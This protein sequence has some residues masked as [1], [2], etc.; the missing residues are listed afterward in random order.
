MKMRRNLITAIL[1]MVLIIMPFSVLANGIVVDQSNDGASWANTGIDYHEPIGQ[2]FIPSMSPLVGVDV[3]LAI[4]NPTYG[5]ANITVNIREDTIDGAIVATTSQL[6]A[7][8]FS[9]WN[10]FEFPSPVSID[11]GETYV[12][13]LV[14]DTITHGWYYNYP[15]P[16]TAGRAIY[17]GTANENQDLLFRTYTYVEPKP[18]I[19]EFS[20]STTGT[21]VEYVE[22]FG[23]PNTDYSAYT[24]LEIEGDSGI[25][26]GT[27]DEVISI[28]TTNASGFWLGSLPSNSL[29]NGTLTLLLVTNF[30]GAL[31]DDLDT[32]DDGIFD[33]TPWDSVVDGVAVNDG[34]AGD[35]AY[36]VPSL[37]VSY[38]GQPFAPGG[39]SRFPDGLDTDTSA[40]WVRNDF[41]LAGIPGYD[42]TIIE[43]EAYNTPGVSNAV[44]MPDTFCISGYKY[45]DFDDVG[46]Q[47][48]QIN[49]RDN[50]GALLAT[51][52]TDADGFYQLCGIMP[53]DYVVEEG[54]R[55]GWQR[56]TPPGGLWEVSVVGTDITNIS[57]YNIEETQTEPGPE[58]GGDVYPISKFMLYIPMILVAAALLTGTILVVKRKYG[59]N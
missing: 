31:N 21:D 14:S 25:A 23:E 35:L 19:N 6:I 24:I 44:Y 16:Y 52:Q 5:D 46:I 27:I 34:G 29:E 32:N 15:N 37:G 1:V 53:G 4:L 22:I 42:G 30:T 28:G 26:V 41:D 55:E 57:F 40:D 56:V 18:V 39:A 38:D 3:R 2:E 11:T 7:D 59:H 20:A 48:W 9:G 8:D 33:I 49:L 50:A 12:L 13:E 43:G 51:T 58:V 10:Y 47:G 45:D 54:A 36:A 17:E